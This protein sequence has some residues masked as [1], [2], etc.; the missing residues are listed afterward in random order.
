MLRNILTL[1]VLMP[2]AAYA[3]L[4]NAGTANQPA[5]TTGNFFTRHFLGG[6]AAAPVAPISTNQEVA[7]FANRRGTVTQYPQQMQQQAQQPQAQPQPAMQQP[8][9][10]PNSDTAPSPSSERETPPRRSS[11]SSTPTARHPHRTPK[12]D[13]DTSD[14]EVSESKSKK[15]S[16]DGDEGD[17]DQMVNKLDKG[18]S[19]SEAKAAEMEKELQ[20]SAEEATTVVG[21]LLKSANDGKYSEAVTW[22]T[23]ELQKYFDSEL[24]AVDGGAKTILDKLTRNGDIR[25]VTYASAIVRGEGA[26]VEADL[27]FGSGEPEKRMFDLLKTKSGWKVILPLNGRG[28]AATANSTPAPVPAATPAPAAATAFGGLHTA[29]T[30]APAMTPMVRAAATVTPV[31]IDSMSSSGATHH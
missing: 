2:V 1:A 12:P 6:H 10:Q 24:S 26:V 9:P 7:Q 11:A 19:K 27:T 14:T 16:S 28:Q 5:A 15:K 21:K 20:K 25:S 23:P 8:Q 29:S 18:K 22:L 30:P 13:S 4:D 31:I 17:L 3:A